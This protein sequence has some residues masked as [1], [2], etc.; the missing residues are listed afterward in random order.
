MWLW[1]MSSNEVPLVAATVT[2]L[3]SA[4]VA[5][6]TAIFSFFSTKR[7]D[8][9]R[10]RL[11]DQ[12]S[13]DNARRA[14]E[15]EARKRL[16]A[17]VEPLLFSLFEA[18]E[19]AFHA[20]ASLARSRRKGKLPS[21]LAQDGYYLRSTMYRLLLPL[22]ILRLLQSSTTLVDLALDTS[23]K[24]RYR[25]LKECYLTLTDDFAISM[26]QPEIEYEPNVS[27]WR[28]LRTATPSKYWRQGFVTGHLDRTIDALITC[29]GNQSR[30]M[31]FG[32][33]EHASKNCQQFSETFGAARDLLIG[34]DFNNR[35]VLGR[36]L[37]AYAGLLHVLMSAYALPEPQDPF[38]QCMSFI[39]LPEWDNLLELGLSISSMNTLRPYIE[40]R[41][42]QATRKEGYGRF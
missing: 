18:A 7:L 16:Y 24:L 37:I 32:E 28:E 22:V 6:I 41:I 36:I 19:G 4:V 29:D 26:L 40:R 38:S 35:P 20:V 13:A 10:A 34:F 17:E 33:V 5:T 11:A 25:I 21:W 42:R 14:Y 9:E 23:I 31:N 12:T 3:G 1:N 39:D 8:K 2:A 15:Y 27:N 30:P